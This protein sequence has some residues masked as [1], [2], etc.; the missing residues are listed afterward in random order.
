MQINNA[1]IAIAKNVCK[2]NLLCLYNLI[3]MKHCTN[4]MAPPREKLF[5]KKF[6]PCPLP[7]HF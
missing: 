4:L 3:V 2:Q 5:V 7:S 1:Y 6:G